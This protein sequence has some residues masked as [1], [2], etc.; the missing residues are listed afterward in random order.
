MKEIRK[1]LGIK[2]RRTGETG[3]L[4]RTKMSKMLSTDVELVEGNNEYKIKKHKIIL[5]DGI[6]DG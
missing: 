6:D 2:K 3:E 4:V 1:L 5:I